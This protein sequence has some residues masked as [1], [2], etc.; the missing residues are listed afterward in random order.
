MG[1]CSQQAGFAPCGSLEACGCEPE[2]C[3]SIVLLIVMLRDEPYCVTDN[4]TQY[5]LYLTRTF[6][7]LLKV[8]DAK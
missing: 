8:Y 1:T 7:A 2:K 3:V 4:M 5:I 6:G